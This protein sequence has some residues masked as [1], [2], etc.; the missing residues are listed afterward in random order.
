MA[1]WRGTTESGS[2]RA[3]GADL[4]DARR[5]SDRQLPP[6]RHVEVQRGRAAA[7][8]CRPG[9]RLQGARAQSSRERPCQQRNRHLQRA[10]LHRAESAAGCGL[11]RDAGARRTAPVCHA[12]ASACV[13]ALA[14]WVAPTL[15]HHRT[16]GVEHAL[17]PWTTGQDSPPPAAAR[18]ARSARPALQLQPRS[19]HLPPFPVREQRLSGIMANLLAMDLPSSDEEDDDYDIG[20]DRTG[21]REDM[22]PSAAADKR[23]QKKTRG[24]KRG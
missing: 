12:R 15:S 9:G 20:A 10:L 19:P 3:A 21:E 14:I 2:C 18:Y 11:R 7:A 13:R 24:V 5:V 17:R 16:W 6:A 4:R 22:A 23:K 1:R 8:S